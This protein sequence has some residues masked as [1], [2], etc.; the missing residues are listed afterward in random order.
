[1]REGISVMVMM[2]RGKVEKV[3]REEVCMYLSI[4]RSVS[5]DALGAFVWGKKH[6]TPSIYI[7]SCSRR[8][9]PHICVLFVG[10]SPVFCHEPAEGPAAS[11]KRETLRPR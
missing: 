11:T 4:E 8:K 1:M 3:M 5:G 2:G 9:K 6:F 10:C 7:T